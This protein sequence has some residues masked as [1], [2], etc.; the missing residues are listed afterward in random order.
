M[1]GYEL[2]KTVTDNGSVARGVCST[3]ANG[4]LT[5][6]HER[7][8]IEVQG[9]AIRFTE[10]GE[11]WTELAPDTVVSMN[12]WGF[13]PG[14]L[15]ELKTKFATFIAE[16]MPKNPEKAEFFLPFAVADLLAE[17]KARAKVLHS[18]DK[19]YGIT[20]AAD[21]PQIV[22]AL[23]RMAEEGKYPDSLWG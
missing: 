2:G 12:T 9:D 17:G 3:D 1:V 5:D 23:R 7:T 4:Y 6:I 20:Y 14:F 8:R 16:E 11:N 22:A 21:K 15:K 13:T 10:D 18:A 19:W